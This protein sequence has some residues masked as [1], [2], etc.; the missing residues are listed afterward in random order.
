MSRSD[1][2]IP[3]PW[4]AAFCLLLLPLLAQAQPQREIPRDRKI[5]NAFKSIC[6]KAGACTAEVRCQ[7]KQVALGTIVGT[8]GYILTKASQ[9]KGDVVCKIRDRELPAKV[10]GIVEK[11]D[12]ALLKVDARGLA[13]VDWAESKGAPVGNWVA[14]ASPSELPVAVGI[15]SVA[16]RTLP[17]SS[18]GLPLRARSGGYLGVAVDTQHEAAKITQIMP[19][20]AADKAGLQVD[21]IVVKVNDTTVKNLDGFLETLQQHKPGETVTLHVKRGD[22]E[23]DI[24]ATLGKRPVGRSDFQNSLGSELS[25]RRGGFPTIL[26]HDSVLRARDCGGPLCDLDGKVI[27]VNIARAGRTE[28]Y[29]IP[30]EV[31]R[32]LLPELM[33]GKL[34]PKEVP[35]AL[36]TA[37]AALTKAAAEHTTAE[38]KVN[39]AKAALRKAEMARAAAEK[40][41][42]AARAALLK[43]EG[44]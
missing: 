20:S 6:R 18:R 11:H 27:G 4:L 8:D 10:V 42:A 31:I 39:E 33:S 37:R 17:T 40:K 16:T 5:L 43:A 12:L 22:K 34:A 13:A 14:S 7:G 21:D 2:H 23:L 44:K 30:S 41:L 28:S 3:R 38:T 32:P 29:A 19:K 1:L 35:A 25:D 15:V 26:Q 36:K 9:L 24:E